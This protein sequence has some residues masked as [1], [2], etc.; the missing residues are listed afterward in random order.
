[1][2]SIHKI[3]HITSKEKENDG[4]SVMINGCGT[5]QNVWGKQYSP[6]MG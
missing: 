6:W 2:V 1:M 4:W 3:K 5:N